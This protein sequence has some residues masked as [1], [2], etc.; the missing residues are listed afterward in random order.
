[1]FAR[2]DKIFSSIVLPIQAD[3][4]LALQGILLGVLRLLAVFQAL[5]HFGLGRNDFPVVNDG[6]L[7]GLDNLLSCMKTGGMLYLSVLIGPLG[8]ELSRQ[9]DLS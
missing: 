4:V 2:L 7:L 8:V 1:M 9:R 6:H 3:L 5:E